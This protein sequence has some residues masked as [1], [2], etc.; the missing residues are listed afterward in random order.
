MDGKEKEYFCTHTLGLQTCDAHFS[1]TLNWTVYA[2][3]D[4]SSFMWRKSLMVLVVGMKQP[5]LGDLLLTGLDISL[6]TDIHEL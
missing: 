2:F 5:L 6:F 1:K 4:I 3:A